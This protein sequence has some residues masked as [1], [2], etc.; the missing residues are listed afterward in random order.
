MLSRTLLVVSFVVLASWSV[1]Q[2]APKDATPE[3]IAANKKVLESLP[4]ANK[5]DFEDAKRGF[6]ATLP[7]VEI[8]DPNGHVVW[9]LKPYKFLE[10]AEA[11]PTVN[12]SLWRM[13]QLN[14]DSGLFKVTD[15][16]YQ[17]RAF[18]LSNMTIVEG[19]TGVIVIDPLISAEVAKAGMDLY[20]ANRPK[21]PVKAVIY[22]HSHVDHF[23]GVKGVVSEADVK[24]GKVKIYA[25]EGFL[26]EAVSENVY[27]GNA[28]SRRA[29]YMYG[30]LLPK[31]AKGQVDG[32]LG[33]TTSIGTVT[34]IPPTDTIKKTGEK[35][36]I[37]GLEIL[38]QMA[39]G[40]EAPAEMLFFIP[41]YKA[42]C[43]AEDA[44]HTVHNLYTLRGAQVRDANMWWKALN[45]T[46]ALFGAKTDVVFASH[47]WPT[48]GNQNVV[49]L[50]E[51]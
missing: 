31:G 2:E 25:P 16:I 34:L 41:R 23:G 51:K 44:T 7:D 22:T 36:V 42:L 43:A 27:A 9:D 21:K 28:M 8:K 49:T 13:A 39:P 19:N 4:F 1:A 37:D 12:P 24:A 11:P 6:V 40:T 20:F 32:G 18:D 50:I 45:E 47:H 15:G 14:M 33:K 30:A 10:A 26:E 48:W 46:L 35:R 29:L 5:D 17:V 38:F 3:T